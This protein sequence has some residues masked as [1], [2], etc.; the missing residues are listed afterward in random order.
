[1]TKISRTLRVC[2][3][4]TSIVL[5]IV[6]THIIL[7]QIGGVESHAGAQNPPAKPSKY[8]TEYNWS[9]SPGGDLGQPGDKLVN[10]PSC[11]PGVT[12]KEPEY[13]G[14]SQRIWNF[15]T[16]QGHGWN[17]C[18]GWP[19]GKLA[20]H[21]RKCAHRGICNLQRVRWIAGGADRGAVHSH[22]SDGQ[23]AIRN[24]FFPS[25]TLPM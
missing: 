24:Q 1:M 21:D 22:Q 8:A 25:P 9:M 3:G 20:V 17:L 14:P 5:L 13:W 19:S 7:S 12:G 15:G 10:L 2:L 6:L 4:I 23:P 11:P 16:G 18:G